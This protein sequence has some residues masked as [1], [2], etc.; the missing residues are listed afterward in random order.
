[1]DRRNFL[2]GA[3]AAAT[4]ASIHSQAYAA[5]PS[6]PRR[7]G[8]IGCG[9]YGKCDLL[10]LMNVEP[11]EV[12]SL[13]DVDS[14]MLSTAADL[15]ASRQVS[16]KRPRTYANFQ[17][18]LDEQDLDI[19]LV[20]T[21]DHWHALAMI[22]A[23]DAGADVYVQKPTGCDVLESK[24]MLDAARRTGRVVQVGT[25]RRSTPH[26]ID[27]KQQVVDAGLLGDVAYAEVCCYYHMRANKNPPDTTPPKN[28]DYDAWTGPAPMRPYN[29]LVH[30]RSWRAFMEYGNGIVGDMC[31]HMLDMVRWQLDLGWPQRISS[32]GGILVDV[33][34]KANITDTQTATF[35]FDDLDVVWTHRSWGSAPDPEYPWA[36]IIYGTK[37]TLKLSVNKFDFI[38][39]GGGQ[40]IH[41]DAL[42]ELDKYPTDQSDKKDWNME[43]HVASAIRGHMRDF[44]KAIDARSKP[45]AD[46]E[47]GHISSAS[48]I[49]A[50]NALTLGR[51]IQFDPATHTAVGDDE[52]TAL[53]KR[54][55]R[56]PYIHPATA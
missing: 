18:M 40:K 47:Q 15:I 27:A 4:V 52:A 6:K 42:I 56:A 5:A 7:V 1:M 26:L 22:A 35:D 43:L 12:V 44:L 33:D 31:V 48:C 10:Q 37:G 38:P 41:G 19:V 30:P 54:P 39:R 21:P 16:K 51:T 20:A 34:S 29:E 25:Q 13:C 32:T 8:L 23:V 3:T 45:I 36:G 11:V 49:M 53:L 9:W 2:R 28:L 46:I 55:Y 24:A 17:E 50:N 14:T